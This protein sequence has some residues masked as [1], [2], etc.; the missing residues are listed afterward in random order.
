MRNR[1][2]NWLIDILQHNTIRVNDNQIKILDK[3]VN[4]LIEKNK[5]INLI[6][7]KDE[8]NVWESHILHSLA[9]QFLFDFKNIAKIMDIG[10]GGGLPGI[11]LKIFNENISLDLVDSIEKKINAVKMFIEQLELKN[12]RALCSRVENLGMNYSGKYDLIICRAVAPLKNLINWSKPLLKKNKKFENFSDG[13]PPISIFPGTLLA[14][15]GGNLDNEIKEAKGYKNIR[16]VDIN[17]NGYTSNLLQDKK[18]VII[19]F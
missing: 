4:L 5:V 16:V 19:N 15:K 8:E 12:T 7:R 3:Y 14:M 13:T 9:L 2:I 6:S 1:N 17:I 10:T 11:P 18:V